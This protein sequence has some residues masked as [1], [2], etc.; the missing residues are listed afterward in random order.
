AVGIRALEA[1]APRAVAAPARL[2]AVVL[3]GNVF[4]APAR[5]LA[6]PLLL[7]VPTLAKA[8]SRDDSLARLLAGALDEVAP[9]LSPCLEIVTSRGG[10]TDVPALVA[11]A[12]VISVYGSDDTA[13]AIRVAAPANTRVVVHGHGLGVAVVSVLPVGD[14]LA[15]LCD[16]L[17]DDV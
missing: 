7:G 8:S 3:S 13:R 14:E 17:A 12:D 9:D 16:A 4:T 2:A 15:A 5:A 1:E 11:Q 10:D 6:L